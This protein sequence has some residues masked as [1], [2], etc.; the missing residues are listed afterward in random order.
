[1][2]NYANETA[3]RVDF[4]R[5][6]VQDAGAAGIIFGNSGGKDA[7]LT[8]ILCKASGVRTIGVITPCY[9][10]RNYW[11]DRDDALLLARAF[12]IETL[13]VDLTPAR[14]AIV[15]AVGMELSEAAVKNI[16]PRLRM[17]AWYAMGQSMNCLIAGTGNRSERH[18]GYFTKWGDGAFDFNPIADLTV[19]EVYEFLRHLG[20]PERII[21][22][23]PSAGLYEGQTDEGELGI[24]YARIDE[25][26]LT[27]VASE[28]DRTLV[29]R[30]HRVSAHKRVLPP[31][32][33]VEKA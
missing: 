27:G 16:A 6:I 7:A 23:A 30:M 5:G 26:L 20:A 18:I 12:D 28:A 10:K 19:T 17:T 15:A 25:Y 32:Y 22:K 11:E 29:D 9:S 33:G 2:R 3:A 21:T 4:I 31:M 13:E 14:A 1:M 24:S 8:G